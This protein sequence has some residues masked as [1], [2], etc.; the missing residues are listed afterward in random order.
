M[1]E[2]HAAGRTGH[3]AHSP[4]R[5]AMV[6]VVGFENGP[7]AGVIRFAQSSCPVRCLAGKS[8]GH[9]QIRPVKVPPPRHWGPLPLIFSG[10]HNSL[11]LHVI[12]QRGRP[13]CPTATH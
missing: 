13:D 9:M 6:A 12:R 4:A 1:R 8:R 7:C 2:L 5:W 3:G 11:L 10:G